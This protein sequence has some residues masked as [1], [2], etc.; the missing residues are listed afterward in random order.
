MIVLR[1]GEERQGDYQGEWRTQVTKGQ[2]M[3]LLANDSSI[4]PAGVKVEDLDG[5]QLRYR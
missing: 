2:I 1:P 5:P 4:I 3:F